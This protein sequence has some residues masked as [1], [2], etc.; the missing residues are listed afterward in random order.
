MTDQ[1]LEHESVDDSTESSTDYGREAHSRSDYLTS[2]E[3]LRSLP[4]RG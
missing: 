2:R 3:Q 1:A 4:G